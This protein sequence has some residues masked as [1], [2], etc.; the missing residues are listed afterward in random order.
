M[1]KFTYEDKIKIYQDRKNGMSITSVC[2]KYKIQRGNM[3]YLVRLIDRHGLDILRTTKNK[4]YPVQEKEKIIN[5]VILN[6]ESILSVTIDSK[7][8]SSGM[9]INRLKKYKENGY[10]IVERKRGR[11][12]TIMK[13][14]K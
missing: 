5:R 13:K 4:Y 7:L 1:T 3:E 11:S 12:P 14:P 10:N 2:S 9:L 8:P 6:N